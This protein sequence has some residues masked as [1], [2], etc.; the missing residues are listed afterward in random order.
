MFTTDLKTGSR[1]VVIQKS[2]PNSM[3]ENKSQNHHNRNRD[4]PSASPQIGWTM[5][6]AISS[7]A[8]STIPLSTSLAITRTVQP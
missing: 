5:D 6:L 8:L 7:L 4:L 3:D 1:I 2:T